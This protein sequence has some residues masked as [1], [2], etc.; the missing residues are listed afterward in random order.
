VG[1]SG[2]EREYI[3]ERLWRTSKNNKYDVEDAEAELPS[4]IL[5][6]S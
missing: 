1:E 2:R 3:E 4:T 6:I 5:D